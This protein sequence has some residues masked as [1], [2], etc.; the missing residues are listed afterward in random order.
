MPHRLDK[1]KSSDESPRGCDIAQGELFVSSSE[2]L[3]HCCERYHY[4]SGPMT[5]R[6]RSTPQVHQI[7]AI[8]EGYR[9]PTSRPEHSSR[10]KSYNSQQSADD[11]KTHTE[12]SEQ[13]LLAPEPANTIAETIESVIETPVH[14]NRPKLNSKPSW[15]GPLPRSRAPSPGAQAMSRKVTVSYEAPDLLPPVYITTTLSKPQWEIIEMDATKHDQGYI[16]HKEFDSSEGEQQYKFRLGPGDWW[17][18]D[19]N[20]PTIEDDDGNRNNVLYITREQTLQ[21]APEKKYS[22]VGPSEYAIAPSKDLLIECSSNCSC[23]GGQIR[24]SPCSA[25]SKHDDRST[26]TSSSR[27]NESVFA[28]ARLGSQPHGS[29]TSHRFQRRKRGT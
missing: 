8:F 16:F 2:S 28:C 25:T 26:G 15:V 17:V 13:V 18:C 10:G 29:R 27:S 6:S 24:A 1:L 9:H 3:I 5:S 21:A 14:N 20:K 4:N 19:E 12:Q 11:M 22:A 23:D 7:K